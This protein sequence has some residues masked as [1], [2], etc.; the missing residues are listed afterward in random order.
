MAY[1]AGNLPEAFSLAVATHISMCDQCRA[2]LESFDAV[3]GALL[4]DSSQVSVDT[5][6]L[7][8]T[9]SM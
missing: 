6:A 1:S 8:R 5:D 2:A 9:L 4:E 3:G 7:T